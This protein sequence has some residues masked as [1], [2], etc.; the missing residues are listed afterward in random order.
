MSSGPQHSSVTTIIMLAQYQR[1]QKTH[2]LMAFMTAIYYA[3]AGILN[4][5]LVCAGLYNSIAWVQRV[6]ERSSQQM[7]LVWKRFRDGAHS[8]VSTIFMLNN[9]VF[10]DFI[11]HIQC[12][13]ANFPANQPK[14]SFTPC[15]IQCAHID[16]PKHR[17]AA[18]NY[19]I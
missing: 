12:N 15:C 11:R 1:G 14:M 13:M 6:R 7:Q 17:H 3:S 9:A 19:T 4:P 2:V 8:H 10:A 16:R 5:P 18:L